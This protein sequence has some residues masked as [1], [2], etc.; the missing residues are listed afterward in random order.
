MKTTFWKIMLCVKFMVLFLID[1]VLSL[2]QKYPCPRVLTIDISDGLLLRNRSILKNDIIFDSNNYF[3]DEKGG[4]R[5]CICKIK[6]CLRKCCGANEKLIEKKCVQT[7]Q[8]LQVQVYE[9]KQNVSFSDNYHYIYN[10][11]CK[12]GATVLIPHLVTEEEFF[13]QK[14]GSLFLPHYKMKPMRDLQDFCIDRFDL[15]DLDM[16]DMISGLVCI[17]E[18]D[19][20]GEETNLFKYIGKL[21]VYY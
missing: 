13:L 18:D 4:K 12:H 7:A 8:K 9:G 6:Q 2:T 17:L 10:K 3:I 20:I 16:K 1:G 15:E 19:T 14:N 5:G 11:E 21:E